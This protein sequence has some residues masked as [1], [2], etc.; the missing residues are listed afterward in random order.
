MEGHAA[1]AARRAELERGLQAAL[2]QSATAGEG[3]RTR[4]TQSASAAA[5]ALAS[6]ASALGDGL[7]RGS[8]ALSR[9]ATQAKDSTSS[10]VR[11]GPVAL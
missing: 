6:H 1:G 8:H 2:A 7:S 3:I 10:G 11:R 4:S 5:A 9:A